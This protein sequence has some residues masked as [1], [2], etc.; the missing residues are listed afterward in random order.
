MADAVCTEERERKEF[1]YRPFHEAYL[2]NEIVCSIAECLE[3]FRFFKESGLAQ[4]FRTVHNRQMVPQDTKNSALAMKRMFG[5]ETLRYIKYIS[6]K[7][8]EVGFFVIFCKYKA[9]STNV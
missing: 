4:H 1:F 8:S 6:E 7:K 2:T 5:E 3:N 9:F